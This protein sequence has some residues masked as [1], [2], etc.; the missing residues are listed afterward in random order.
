[1]SSEFTKFFDSQR[2]RKRLSQLAELKEHTT[3]ASAEFERKRRTIALE[4][5][6]IACL[7]DDFK[8]DPRLASAFRFTKQ[9][10][11]LQRPELAVK[12]EN[13]VLEFEALAE[14]DHAQQSETVVVSFKARRWDLVETECGPYYLDIVLDNGAVTVENLYEAICT[15]TKEFIERYY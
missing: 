13:M 11:D 4:R 14:I 10:E 15:A 1:M 6:A 9:P 3:A 7:I 2:E 5:A 8:H 12:H